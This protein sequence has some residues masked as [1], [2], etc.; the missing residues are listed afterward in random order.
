[1]TAQI[2]NNGDTKSTLV[3]QQRAILNAVKVLMVAMSDAT[4]NGRNYQTHN[5]P[6]QYSRDRRQHAADCGRI[7]DF[8]D[9]TLAT[10]I[11]LMDQ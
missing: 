5:D 1:M 9:R 3:D 11:E 7:K 6:E 4:P 2:N 8:A 10:G